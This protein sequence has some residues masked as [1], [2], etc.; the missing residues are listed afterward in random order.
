MK[1]REYIIPKLGKGDK[2][3][4]GDDIFDKKYFN[5]ALIGKTGSGKTTTIYNI[6]NAFCDK[7]TVVFFYVP[8]EDLDP[9]YESIKKLLDSKEIEYDFQEY[10][11]NTFEEAQ[12]NMKFLLKQEA[13][14]AELEKRKP[15]DL[16]FFTIFDDVPYNT[17]RSKELEYFSRK[18]RHY[19]NR[20]IISTQ[21][22]Q[23]TKTLFMQL[24]V[25]I[26]YGGISE[27]YLK[28]IYESYPMSISREEFYEIYKE[29]TKEPYKFLTIIN[30]TEFRDGLF[31]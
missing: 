31:K 9:G 22:P 7:N 5:L 10:D 28:H 16:N 24:Y 12:N 26:L 29:V 3:F 20:L 27:Y 17:L 21:S 23:I 25:V 13:Q 1:K 4:K 11:I 30:G 19:H 2:S 8:T 6:L 14:T 18:S 15:D